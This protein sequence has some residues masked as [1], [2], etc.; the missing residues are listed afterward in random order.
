[1]R[2][3]HKDPSFCIQCADHIGGGMYAAAYKVKD[4]QQLTSGLSRT[5]R[6]VVACTAGLPGAAGVAGAPRAAH[7]AFPPC[8]CPILSQA[9]GAQ[10]LHQKRNF[11]HELLSGGT[12][13]QQAH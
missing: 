7:P 9:F 4:V 2:R 1:M 3:T 13:T 12:T 11:S 8:P 10:P 5:S 6:G